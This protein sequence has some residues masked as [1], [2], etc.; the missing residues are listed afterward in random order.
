MKN[1]Y[2]LFQGRYFEQ[3]EGAAMGLPISSIVA[4][5][6]VEDFEIKAL[7]TS[8]HPSVE[9]MCDDTF[10]VIKSAYKRNFLEY[11]NSID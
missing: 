4:N 7:S 8:P 9:K 5:L 11:I 3:L 2:F 6:Y 1:A 10:A